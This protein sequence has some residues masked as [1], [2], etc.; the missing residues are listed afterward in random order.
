M[1]LVLPMLMVTALIAPYAQAAT[2]NTGTGAT[3]IYTNTG[4]D[5]LNDVYQNVWTSNYTDYVGI[6]PTGGVGTND[7]NSGVLLKIVTPDGYKISSVNITFN[8]YIT[9]GWWTVNSITGAAIKVKAWDYDPGFINADGSNNTPYG[10]WNYLS[11]EAGSGQY[12]ALLTTLTDANGQGTINTVSLNLSD[13]A[14]ANTNTVLL[15]FSLL[16]SSYMDTGAA[17]QLFNQSGSASGL[18]ITVGVVPVPEPAAIS[19][20]ALGGTALM[21][22]RRHA[23]H[24]K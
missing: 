3:F 1:K 16:T 20:L 7:N 21:S 11:G 5:V 12:P 10:V 22:R 4:G 24:R 14:D 19:L 17:L 18:T 23:I 15:S 8:Y 2:I 13:V 6:N 9:P